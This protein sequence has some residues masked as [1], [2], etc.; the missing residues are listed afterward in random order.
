MSDR[1][2]GEGEEIEQA[3]VSLSRFLR[4]VSEVVKAVPA[5][6]VRI[7]IAQLQV[8][9]SSGHIY[10]EGVEHDEA[11][12]EIAKCRLTLWRGQRMAVEGKFEAAT[13]S[14]L[15]KGMKIL[16]LLR[17][18][19]HEQYGFTVVLEDVDPNFTL[20]DM[21]RK[22][23][24]IR[25]TLTRERVIDANRSLPMPSDYTVVCVISP[26][27][28]AGLGDFMEVAGRLSRYGLCKFHQRSALFQG[29][30]APNQIHALLERLMGGLAKGHQVDTV[31][32][33]RG[34]GSAADLA[35]LNDLDLARAI[36]NMPIPVY[37]AIGHERDRTILDEVAKCAFDTPSKA[38]LHIEEIIV[39]N[40]RYAE[41]QWREIRQRAE[42][43]LRLMEAALANNRQQL[44]DRA[45]QVLN[46]G[47]TTISY[48]REQVANHAQHSIERISGQLRERTVG[49]GRLASGK[50]AMLESQIAR[51]LV[52]IRSLPWRH[53]DKAAATV[54]QQRLHYD[55][56]PVRVLNRGE[57]SVRRL[58]ALL[59][60]IGPAATMRRGFALIRKLDGTV[61]TKTEQIA[62]EETFRVEMSDGVID[63]RRTK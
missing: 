44:A 50:L 21:Q 33:L 51:N 5:Q 36:C 17:P 3:S 12:R 22:L 46:A 2:E 41:R 27:G 11:G 52:A 61:A 37:T 49:L 9:A 20:G 63:A 58:A 54:S 23:R 15:V 34:G 8:H 55:H 53:L 56:L 6:W 10:M 30:E 39:A 26:D 13:G 28:A 48:R 38:A 43:E 32:I 24:M 59:L 31:V 14:K 16:G 4:Q 57:A 40:A 47:V 62:V 60:G 29:T 1:R 42:S 45:C 7:E 35:W 19:F 25:E 18:V